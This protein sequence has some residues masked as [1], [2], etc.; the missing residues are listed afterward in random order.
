[1]QWDYSIGPGS[2]PCKQFA[3]KFLKFL[4]SSQMYAWIWLEAKLHDK[5]NT[6]YCLLGWGLPDSRPVDSAIFCWDI[7]ETGWWCFSWRQNTVPSGPWPCLSRG[8]QIHLSAPGGWNYWISSREYPENKELSPWTGF[9]KCKGSLYIPSFAA[10]TV[11]SDKRP[12]QVSL[13]VDI[14]GVKVKLHFVVGSWIVKWH[15]PSTL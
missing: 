10:L 13:W 7:P 5:P 11:G 1:M 4:P 15:S 6:Q 8:K 14:L 9:P 12:S 3:F 2:S